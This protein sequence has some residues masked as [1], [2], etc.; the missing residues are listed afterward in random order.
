MFLNSC[1]DTLDLMI[2]DIWASIELCQVEGQPDAP[3]WFM[4]RGKILKIVDNSGQ[5]VPTFCQVLMETQKD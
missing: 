5:L 3:P 4:L 2:F 1:S